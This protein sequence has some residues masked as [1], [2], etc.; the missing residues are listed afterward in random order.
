MRPEN[1]T[2]NLTFS[3][4]EVHLETIS[5][6]TAYTPYCLLRHITKSEHNNPRDI[7]S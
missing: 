3:M 4:E 1:L 5:V 7:S 6:G 2:G